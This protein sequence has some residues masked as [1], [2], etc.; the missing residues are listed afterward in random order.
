[1][2]QQQRVYFDE[3]YSN[4]TTCQI[5]YIFTSRD[6]EDFWYLFS[7]I[8]FMYGTII[9]CSSLYSHFTFIT[10]IDLWLKMLHNYN[11]YLDAVD[12]NKFP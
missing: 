7:K 1:M 10:N 2:Q 6:G 11:L 9:R 4:L 12:E 5:N 3:E 8:T